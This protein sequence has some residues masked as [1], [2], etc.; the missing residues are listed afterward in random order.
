[1]G[2]GEGVNDSKRSSVSSKTITARDSR[3]GEGTVLGRNVTVQ[4][5]AIV[6]A[7]EVGEGTIIEVGAYLG[8]GCVIGKVCHVNL[9]SA[10]AS[11]ANCMIVLHHRA[12]LCPTRPHADSRLYDCAQRDGLSS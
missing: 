12:S 1:M 5:T 7:A 11:D 10:T 6:E 4:A 3:R 9:S 8:K 2:M